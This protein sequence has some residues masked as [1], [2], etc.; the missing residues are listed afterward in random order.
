[1]KG[2]DLLNLETTVR[3]LEEQGINEL[4]FDFADG[5]FVP[6]YGFSPD[7]I[8]AVKTVSSLPC[9]AHLQVTQPDKML[10]A[11]LAAGIDIVTLHVE[12][13]THAHRTLAAIRDAGTQA[14]IAV[15]PTTSLTKLNYLLP[16]ADRV[17][18]VGSHQSAPKATM[19]RGTF[20]RVKILRE[21]LRYHEYS[22]LLE[23]EGPLR[24]E[25]AARCARFG[26]NQLIVDAGS[27]PGLGN[28]ERPGALRDYRS[29]IEATAHTV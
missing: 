29:E 5:H 18:L 8:A 6:R 3:T 11:I 14:G 25:D 28:P 27:L 13:C 9:H 15:N 21:N 16:L 19:P 23:V 26:A 12:T 20:E 22:A 1:M 2:L 24:P 7:L 17:L 10:P 4:H